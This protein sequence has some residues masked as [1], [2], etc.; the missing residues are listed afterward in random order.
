MRLDL[1]EKVVKIERSCFSS[2]WSFSMFVSELTNNNL[3][4]YIAAFLENKLIGYG[5]MWLVL[6]TAHITCVA[7]DPQFRSQKYGAEIL[8]EL[9]M[10]AFLLGASKMTL[11]VRVSNIP[12]R[13]LYSR[14]GFEERGR[15]KA[16]YSDNNEDA[17]IMWKEN[18]SNYAVNFNIE[19]GI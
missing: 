11:E 13:H 17:V 18:L 1:L 2:P 6:D 4:H 3:A 15:R 14:F 7:V 19:A 5:G 8:N 10:Q 9:I 12:A 16:Y